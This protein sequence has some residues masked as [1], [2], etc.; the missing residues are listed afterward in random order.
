MRRL[1][2]KIQ[3]SIKEKRDCNALCFLDNHRDTS[4]LVQKSQ[5]YQS[6]VNRSGNK[7]QQPRQAQRVQQ[8]SENYQQQQYQNDQYNTNNSGNR[9]DQNL[10]ELDFIMKEMQKLN[11]HDLSGRIEGYLR[12]I[13]NHSRQMG[14]N[15][16]PFSQKKTIANIFELFVKASQQYDKYATNMSNTAECSSL[17]G[18]RMSDQFWEAIDQHMIKIDKPINSQDLSRYA[19]ACF[20]QDKFTFSIKFLDKFCQSVETAIDLSQT[21]AVQAKFK[22]YDVKN[23]EKILNSLN[24]GG[25]FEQKPNTLEKL[26]YFF[27]KNLQQLEFKSLFDIGITISNKEH[28]LPH[29]SKYLSEFES[30]IMQ[31]NNIQQL[32]HD[33]K[34]MSYLITIYKNMIINR[35]LSTT[36]L[37]LIEIVEKA[38]MDHIKIRRKNIHQIRDQQLQS[39]MTQNQGYDINQRYYLMDLSMFIYGMGMIDC[40]SKETWDLLEQE[41]LDNFDQLNKAD[42][43]MALQGF[44]VGSFEK[45]SIKLRKYFTVCIMRNF[46]EDYVD[47]IK[48]TNL[49]AK[50]TIRKADEA[51]WD[52]TLEKLDQYMTSDNCQLTVITL[53]L[54]VLCKHRAKAVTKEQCDLLTEIIQANYQ[55]L[56]K[57]EST[58]I[59]KCMFRLEN[60]SQEN[61]KNL[62]KKLLKNVKLEKEPIKVL[63]NILQAYV[64]HPDSFEKHYINNLID[65]FKTQLKQL[66]QNQLKSY[67]LLI[68]DYQVLLL[69]SAIYGLGDNELWQLSIE[70]YEKIFIDNN[71]R[72]SNMQILSA[73]AFMIRSTYHSAD[74]QTHSDSEKLL[75]DKLQH[76]TEIYS[77]KIQ[78]V[79]PQEKRDIK[80]FE[81]I[82]KLFEDVAQIREQN[83]QKSEITK[84]LSVQEPSGISQTVQ[85]ISQSDRKVSKV[86]INKEI[87]RILGISN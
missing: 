14:R 19:R 69:T 34:L 28:L 36:S 84:N 4:S 80:R 9:G 26:D 23:F 25:I 56:Q 70:A 53:Y 77:S 29:L 15:Q 78:N 51:L 45:G 10:Q 87:N 48:A 76:I 58:E 20:F 49:I 82:A 64:L 2:R 75:I 68:S 47:F 7:P 6:F 71:L 60:L 16:M 59:L 72:Q 52:Q 61:Q 8:S 17:L 12:R 54:K 37:H 40:G 1:S 57:T 66:L 67:D 55:T 22:A 38:F 74:T 86:D 46:S 43:D 41:L 32:K 62:V 24:R 27:E 33:P 73:I 11:D 42:F 3:Q 44:C 79:I 30:F 13:M 18:L 21:D 65:A 5:R 39:S 50:D 35:K 63:I 81:Y 31:E 85:E 83:I